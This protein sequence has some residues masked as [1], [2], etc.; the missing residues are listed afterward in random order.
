MPGTVAEID[1][2][3][4][5]AYHGGQPFL[6]VSYSHAD[7]D[8]VFAEIEAVHAQGFRIWYDEGIA[9]GNEWPEEIARAL[10][11]SSLFVVFI[12][13]RSVA[14]PH[15]QNEI[16][17]ALNR[18]KPFLAV[19]LED[20]V[21]PVGL[22]LRMGDIQAVKKFRMEPA[23]YVQKLTRVLAGTLGEPAVCSVSDTLLVESVVATSVVQSS[24]DDST[25]T[26]VSTQEKPTKVAV[27]PPAEQHM[28]RLSLR[29]ASP[30]GERNLCLMAGTRFRLGKDR[31]NHIVMRAY[32]RSV[33]NDELSR[34]ISGQHAQ[35]FFEG[36]EVIWK[37]A[38]CANGSVVAGSLLGPQEVC[39]LQNGAAVRP[40]AGP[41]LLV[42]LYHQNA[43]DPTGDYS[44]FGIDPVGTEGDANLPKMVS[45]A[46]LRRTDDLAGFEQYILFP[47]SIM[48]G[49]DLNSPV[50]ISHASVLE[51]HARLLLL[52]GGLWIEPASE[53]ASVIVNER[54]L[55]LH[56]LAAVT[57]GASVR[58]GDVDI[59]VT[60]RFQYGLNWLDPV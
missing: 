58:C 42:D 56:E 32:P 26:V 20:T 33:A 10:D 46:R 8:L 28:T 34:R 44:A 31:S 27:T 9:P 7:S 51:Q 47:R 43:F 30:S 55:S 17:F 37:N 23:R 15:V 49:R 16:N 24:P 4:I 50:L 25:S 36:G 53:Q 6:F 48:I 54:S 2:S 14:S 39:T 59:K 38:D 3:M 19:Y 40:A 52:Q 57:A 11:G 13:P 41:T 22:E 35:I 5:E 12:T 60:P 18:R 21:L 29:I 45:A 1:A